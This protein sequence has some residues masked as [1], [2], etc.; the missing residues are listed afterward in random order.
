MPKSN[1]FG[2]VFGDDVGGNGDGSF[3]LGL[4]LDYP[5]VGSRHGV[6]ILGVV[7]GEFNVIFI[8]AVVVIKLDLGETCF[9]LGNA[10]VPQSNCFGFV[11]GDDI[12][13]CR[14]L[15][16]VDVEFDYPAVGGRN[17]VV[18]LNSADKEF[19]IILKYAVVEIEL[20]LGEADFVL[21]KPGMIK[22]DLLRLSLVDAARGGGKGGG[23]EGEYGGKCEDYRYYFFHVGLP[24]C[25][26]FDLFV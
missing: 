17:G 3:I 4:K 26:C 20:R 21:G 15:L 14:R 13:G 11:F 5:A 7:C 6:V 9:A 22:G 2:F 1:C 23:G 18:I 19:D 12:G 10:C 25:F 16:A 24:F 8:C